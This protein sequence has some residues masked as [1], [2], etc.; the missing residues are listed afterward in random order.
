MTRVEAIIRPLRLDE[1]RAAL[2]EIGV[3]G[4]TVTEVRGYGKQRGHTERYRGTEYTITLLHKAK[5][6]VVVPDDRVDEVV[7]AILASARTGEIGDGKI[8]LSPIAESIRIRTGE[9]G[10]D[11]L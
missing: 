9:R 11:S 10:D 4:M 5:L 3:R 8:F 2:D 7:E 6:E 1:V